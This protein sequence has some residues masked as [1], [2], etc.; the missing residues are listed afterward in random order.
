MNSL[1]NPI[2][3]PIARLAGLLAVSFTSLVVSAC[4]GADPMTG[5]WVQPDATT[6]LPAAV[7]GG[8]LAIDATLDL[9]ATAA[10]FSLLMTLEASGL[11][12]SIETG[13]TYVDDGTNLTLT[14][15]GFVIDPASGNTANV[16]EDGS[17]CITLTG[18]AGTAVCFPVPQTN[19]YTIA[20]DSLTVVLDHTIAGAPV[21]QT[22]LSLTRRPSS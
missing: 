20:G 11:V 6:P 19:G 17:Q 13:G 5:S 21:S 2:A 8:D 9:D 18:F 16:A 22:T 14:F 10:T 4:S 12:D 15:T 7:G 1:A 3:N